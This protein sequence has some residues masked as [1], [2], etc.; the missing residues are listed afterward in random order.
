MVRPLT[1]GVAHYWQAHD[2]DPRLISARNP[3][4]IAPQGEALL[5]EAIDHFRQAVRLEPQFALAH[6]ALGQALLARRKFTEAEAEIRRSLD[7]V[8]EGEKTLRAN[9][10][11][12]SRIIRTHSCN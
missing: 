1:E 8:S 2:C 4:R 5:T 9:L 3:L 6:G 11:R 10:E 12:L 7:L